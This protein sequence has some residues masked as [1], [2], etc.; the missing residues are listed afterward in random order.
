MLKRLIL[1][2]LKRQ[3]DD[4]L[5]YCLLAIEAGYPLSLRRFNR[6]FELVWRA[7]LWVIR[8]GSPNMAAVKKDL[9]IG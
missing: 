7:F 9:G 1:A 4:A 2:Y 8:N 6:V 5:D 3:K